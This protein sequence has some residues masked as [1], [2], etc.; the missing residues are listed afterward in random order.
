[1]SDD[2]ARDVILTAY[3][4]SAQAPCSQW[5]KEMF[6]DEPIVL[7]VPGSGGTF[8]QKGQQWAA[9]GDAFRAALHDLAP[10]HK[11]VPI[12]RRAL[13]TF[14]AGWQLPHTMLVPERE[15]QLLDAFILEDGLHSTNMD[16]WVAYAT[17]AARKDAWM[18]MAHSRIKPPFVST[19]ET[20]TAL[21]KRACENND[22]EPEPSTKAD[23]LPDYISNPEIPDGGIKVTVGA[24]KDATGKVVMPAVTKVW[25]KDCLLG[26]DNRGD[27]YR[28]DYDGNDRPDHVYIAWWVAP[29]LWRM[30]ADHWNNQVYLD[31]VTIAA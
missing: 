6:K 29:R 28:L 20:N 11:D 31:P 17:R 9:S 22:K 14:S 7:A 18:V 15:Q 4:C 8:I 23:T 12:R 30:L 27:L 24:S 3:A 25:D 16:H 21:F 2:Q 19:T 1:M 13:V 10:Q 26:W 5:A